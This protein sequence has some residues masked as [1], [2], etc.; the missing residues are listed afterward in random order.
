MN[1]TRKPKGKKVNQKLWTF[2]FKFCRNFEVNQKNKT[3]KKLLLI[4]IITYLA[5]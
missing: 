4:N 5:I 3:T 1:W 2:Y